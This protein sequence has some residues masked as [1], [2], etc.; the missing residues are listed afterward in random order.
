MNA[1]I[2][3]G[4][5]ALLTGATSWGPLGGGSARAQEAPD[6]VLHRAN[7][8]TLAADGAREVMGTH[9]VPPGGALFERT[10]PREAVTL[11]RPTFMAVADQAGR[12]RLH[13]GRPHPRQRPAR[14]RHGPRRG[15]AGARA[16]RVALGAGGRGPGVR[17]G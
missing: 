7:V 14:A 16:G 6:L 11:V 15:R 2:K 12:S 13:G 8:V 5:V 3:L 4:A 10:A 1:I 9:I 17:L